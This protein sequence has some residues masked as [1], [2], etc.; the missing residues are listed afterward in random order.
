MKAATRI[1]I[2]MHEGDQPTRLVEASSQSQAKSVIL[3][4]WVARPATPKEIAQ[5][6]AREP[7][8]VIE[9]VGGE[10]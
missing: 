9:Q 1:Y 7:R 10:A 2:V 4:G 8:T 5:A 6:F 3:Q